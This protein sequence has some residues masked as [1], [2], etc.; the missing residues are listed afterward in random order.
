MPTPLPASAPTPEE[1]RN[2]RRAA[3][4]TGDW[5]EVKALGARVALAVG[6]AADLRK[7]Q[8][9]T[10]AHAQKEMILRMTTRP[11]GR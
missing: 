2:A 6:D 11:G 7:A 10:A 3:Q 5:T 8:L 9:D 1:L 4:L